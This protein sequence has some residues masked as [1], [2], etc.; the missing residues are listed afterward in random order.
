MLYFVK[1]EESKGRQI[2]LHGVPEAA[3]SLGNRLGMKDGDEERDITWLT[4]TLGRNKDRNGPC[5]AK[6]GNRF[7]QIRWWCQE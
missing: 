7:C 5:E 2:I 4:A 1:W 6:Q 3:M